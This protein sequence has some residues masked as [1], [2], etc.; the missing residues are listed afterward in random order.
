MSSETDL[1]ITGGLSALV[2]GIINAVVIICSHLKIKSSCC[3]GTSAVV[4]IGHDIIST[5]QSPLLA[6]V[7]K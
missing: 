2:S 7:K 1:V 5:N 6:S 3:Y 4:E